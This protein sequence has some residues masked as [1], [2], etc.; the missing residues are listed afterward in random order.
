[1]S[2]GW[3]A[4][5]RRASMASPAS[6]GLASPGAS[7]VNSTFR[8]MCPCSPNIAPARID[9]RSDKH[10]GDSRFPGKR[11]QR[12]NAGSLLAVGRTESVHCGQADAKARKR[13]R[14]ACCRKYVDVCQLEVQM[15]KEKLNRAKQ[16][17]G[18][19]NGRGKANFTDNLFTVGHADTSPLRTRVDRQNAHALL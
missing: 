15:L 8:A 2:D 6:A 3:P 7:T 18:V 16:P 9:R 13:S 1:M 10:I 12:R 11:F 14:T 17:L 4:T 19:L 5:I